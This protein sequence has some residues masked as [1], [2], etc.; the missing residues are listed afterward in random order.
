MVVDVTRSA[1]LGYG[2]RGARGGLQT[3]HLRIL[4]A[5][6]GRR[7]VDINFLLVFLITIVEQLFLHVVVGLDCRGSGPLLLR[8][9]E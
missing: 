6:S 8:V 1:G 3:G 4:S 2:S 5:I 7:R 9:C